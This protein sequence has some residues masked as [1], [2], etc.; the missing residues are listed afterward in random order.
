MESSI[1]EEILLTN[2]SEWSIDGTQEEPPLTRLDIF[3]RFLNKEVNIL[4][5]MEIAKQGFQE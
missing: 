1:P 3:M 5:G 4:K 2:S